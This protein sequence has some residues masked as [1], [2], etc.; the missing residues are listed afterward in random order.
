MTYTYIEVAD[1]QVCIDMSSDAWADL[2][3]VVGVIYDKKGKW[4]YL[5]VDEDED[6]VIRAFLRHAVWVLLLI[7]F[8]GISDLMI[9]RTSC[10]RSSSKIYKERPVSRYPS[11]N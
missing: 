8:F 6:L 2:M 7:L 5:D 11:G 9:G 10:A 1:A 4:V 3:Q